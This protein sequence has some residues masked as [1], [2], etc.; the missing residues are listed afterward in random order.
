M[1]KTFE[2][3]EILPEGKNNAISAEALT[4]M[5]QLRSK[6]ELQKRIERERKA[7]A[8]ILSSTTGGYYT[9]H[10]RAEVAEFVRTLESRAKRVT[11]EASVPET[12]QVAAIFRSKRSMRREKLFSCP[13]AELSTGR[14]QYSQMPL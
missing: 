14:M 1:D 4:R 2:I 10:N 7:G 5:L 9:S 11:L 12:S 13:S 6:R 3:M 8:L